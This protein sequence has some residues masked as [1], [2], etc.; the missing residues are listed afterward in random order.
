MITQPQSDEQEAVDNP[1]EEKA[2]ATP[3]QLALVE[4]L[5]G[6]LRDTR[7]F[8]KPIFEKIQANI[9]FAGGDQWEEKKTTSDKYQVNFVQRELNQDV[10]SVYARNPTVTIE[11]KQRLEYR[12]WDGTAPQLEQAKME[13]QA[14][15]EMAAA[16]ALSGGVVAKPPEQAE[17]IVLDYAAGLKR[18]KLLDRIA[19][20]LEKAI[21][22]EMEEQKPDFESQMKS[23]ALREKVTGAGFLSVKFQRET[24]TVQTTTATNTGILEKMQAIQAK[25]RQLKEPEYSQDSACHEEL[26]LMIESLEKDLQAEDAKVLRE[27]VVFDFKPTTSVLVDPACRSLHEFVGAN[28]V[29]ELY[30]LTPERVQEQYGVDVKNSGAVKYGDNG[31]PLAY[32]TDKQGRVRGPNGRYAGAWPEKAKCC[33]AEI[34]D[35]RMQMKYVVCDGYDD[36]LVEPETPWPPVKGFWSILCLKFQR[37]EIEKNDP[38]SGVTIYGQSSV[39]LL[40][41]M[42]LEM[43][44]SQEGKRE[45]RIGNR[46]GYLFPEGVISKEEAALIGSMPANSGLGLKGVPP[47]TDM[48]TVIQAKP[49]VPM[50]PMLYETN[51]V[52]QHAALVVGAQ[53][54]NM[55]QQNTTDKATGQ[56]IAEQSRVEGVSSEVD[57]EDKFLTEAMRVTGEMLLQA[58]GEET[59]RKKVGPGAVWPA[60]SRNA[61]GQQPDGVIT[62]D[63]CLEQFVIKIEA[64]SSGRANRA[65]DIQNFK[66]MW[67]SLIAVAQAMGLSLEPLVREQAKILGFKFDIDEWLASAMQSPLAQ[68]GQA[69]QALMQGRPGGPLPGQ[70]TGTAPDP[71]GMQSRIQRGTV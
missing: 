2:E 12:F 42:Q 44:R 38:K 41:P 11:R 23:L 7:D 5:T 9:E 37:I 63:D 33:V 16:T 59:I 58:A 67:P 45:H 24:E 27:G 51:T 34:Y 31:S 17:M 40:R 26:R 52:M 50:D 18:K 28:R 56:A 70:P 57:E 55:G 30:Y 15:A 4:E 49:V 19:E 71:A 60:S 64:A 29:A 66:E 20:T 62:I 10:A 8:W 6:W 43:N 61:Q 48:R 65:L 1:A 35:K 68:A 14:A 13:L 36:F 54:S 39:D 3:S 53:A 22:F 32:V 69:G 46:P 21:T 25:A 47:G